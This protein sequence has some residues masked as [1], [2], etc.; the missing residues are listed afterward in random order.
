MRP[1]LVRENTTTTTHSSAYSKPNFLG[2]FGETDQH[3]IGPNLSSEP[4]YSE[5]EN[6]RQCGHIFTTYIIPS[7][8]HFAA[9]IIGFIYFRITEN[10][11]L[12]ALMEKVFLAANN[13]LKTFSQ[14]QVIRRLKLF[15]VFGSLWV[16]LAMSMQ[17]LQRLAFGFEQDIYQPSWIFLILQAIGLVLMNS[18]YLAVVINYATQCELLIFFVNELR[19]RLEEKSI[20]L[21]DA[22]QV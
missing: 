10:E 14:D 18:I 11:Q 9:F 7:I 4:R 6:E 5:K 19:T 2:F 21:K 20:T 3:T 17:I 8:M 13:T 22:M 16:V 12:Y 1:A 15:I